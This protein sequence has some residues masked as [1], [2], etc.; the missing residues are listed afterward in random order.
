MIGIFPIV[1]VK[2]GSII[3]LFDKTPI[4]KFSNDV[5]CPHFY[6]LKWA[7]GCNFNCVWYYL[8]GTFRFRPHGKKP[9]KK[10]K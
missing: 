5:V 1:K 7:N 9:Y 6:E 10:Y 4:P 3:T 8:N 2:D